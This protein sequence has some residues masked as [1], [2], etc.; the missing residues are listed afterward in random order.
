MIERLLNKHITNLRK[1]VFVFQQ[2]HDLPDFED[3]GITDTIVF[4]GDHYLFTIDNILYDLFTNQPKGL[5]LEW[6]DTQCNEYK[7]IN[8]YS[9]SMGL[10]SPKDVLKDAKTK[11][12]VT[13][14]DFLNNLNNN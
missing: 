2:K 13:K 6:F 12:E 1:L 7:Q 4:F 14:K 11:L 5:I 3:L 10:R 9:Y 8:F